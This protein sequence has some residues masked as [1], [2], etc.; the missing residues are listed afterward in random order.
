MNLEHFGSSQI[1]SGFNSFTIDNLNIML[2]LVLMSPTTY[3][4]FPGAT[5]DL[6][7]VIINYKARHDII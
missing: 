5:T 4:M 1:N 6:S 2:Y 7:I 3:L